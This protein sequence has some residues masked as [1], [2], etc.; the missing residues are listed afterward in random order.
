M[1]FVGWVFFW[2]GGIRKHRNFYKPLIF[3]VYSQNGQSEKLFSNGRE[4]MKRTREM[5]ASDMTQGK[6]K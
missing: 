1:G 4:R 5:L 2:Q 6:L 3:V